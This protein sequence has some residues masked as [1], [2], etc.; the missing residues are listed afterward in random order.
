[1]GFKLYR[2]LL[3]ADNPVT[4]HQLIVNSGTIAVGDMV[5]TATGYAQRAT[6]GSLVH[7]V[8]VGIVTEDGIDLKNASSDLY[9][10]TY[11]DTTQTYVATSDNVTDKKVKAII[12]SDPFVIW[13]GEADE[14]VAANERFQFFDLVDHDTVDGSENTESE[15]QVQLWDYDPDDAT[16]V[17]VR[18]G[19]WVGFPYAQQS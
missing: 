9:D 8:C 3:G 1:M 4:V 19:E 6:A 11:T 7:G 14:V 2:H 18:I 5:N 17:F 12:V 13:E 15:G 10:G 16:R